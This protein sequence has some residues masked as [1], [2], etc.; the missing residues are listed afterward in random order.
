MISLNVNC[1]T[2]FLWPGRGNSCG[3][4]QPAFPRSTDNGFTIYI[5]TVGFK[6]NRFKGL[7]DVA[8]SV[9]RFTICFPLNSWAKLS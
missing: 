1:K 9:F 7:V 8:L 5:Y 3:S 4:W 6:N 2:L